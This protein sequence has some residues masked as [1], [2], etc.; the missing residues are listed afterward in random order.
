MA[1]APDAP[2]AYECLGLWPPVPALDPGNIAWAA[3]VAEAMAPFASPPIR[4]CPRH[5]SMPVAPGI[6]RGCSPRPAEVPGRAS[7]AAP[8]AREEEQEARS[9]E[10]YGPILVAARSRTSSFAALFE[11]GPK[12]W[13]Q[14]TVGCRLTGS[15]VTRGRSRRSWRPVSVT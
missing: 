7:R 6:P 11:T 3:G 4:R 5:A 13:V 8:P 1:E 9:A 10:I 2:W 14:A 12:F 15:S